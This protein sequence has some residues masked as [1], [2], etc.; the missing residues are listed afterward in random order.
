MYHHVNTFHLPSWTLDEYLSAYG[1]EKFKNSIDISILPGD[2]DEK[3]EDKFVIAGG[4]ARWMFLFTVKE[5]IVEINLHIDRVNTDLKLLSKGLLGV[6]SNTSISHLFC[7]FNNLKET[8]LVSEYA[9]RAIAKI[10][11]PSFLVEARNS[12]LAKSNP[13]FDGWILEAEFLHQLR[14]NEIT[15]FQDFS[16]KSSWIVTSCVHFFNTSDIVVLPETS[17]DNAW[18]V[19]LKWN[20]ACYDVVQILPNNGFRFIQVTKSLS[21]SLKLKYIVL[22]LDRFSELQCKVNSI[23]ICFVVPNELI[24]HKFYPKIPE[25][26]LGKYSDRLKKQIFSTTK[27]RD[28]FIFGFDRL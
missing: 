2:D 11:E 8:F 13:T 4:C 14:F 9:T 27:K 18:F 10:C 19:P 3:I 21:H 6:R 20:Q 24:Y 16:K 26:T 5:V 28:Y 25:G 22:F 12:L 15:L 1:I 7:V 23:E 17:L